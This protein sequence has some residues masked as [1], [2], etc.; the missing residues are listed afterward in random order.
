ME[1]NIHP[2]LPEEAACMG[3]H[4]NRELNAKIGCIGYLTANL[5]A[6]APEFESSWHDRTQILNTPEFTDDFNDMFDT[7]R[8]GVLKS[9]KE[10]RGFC[11]A[12]PDSVMPDSP[13]SDRR[14]GFRIDTGRYSHMLVCSFS[15]TDCRLWVNA[16]SFLALDRHMRE[17]RIGIPI[18]DPQGRE[19]FRMQDGGKLKAVSSNGRSSF[20]TIRYLDKEQAVLFNELR[21]STIH[22]IQELPK[23]AAKSELQLLSL[24]PPMQASRKPYRKGQE[25]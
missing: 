14:Y 25:R 18:L 15:S 19:R 20:W 8:Q 9:P 13:S 5:N 23:W 24:D 16:F 7:L 22:S 2:I 21:Q 10:L 6:S 1:L 12:H 11:A 17:A 3:G 4:S